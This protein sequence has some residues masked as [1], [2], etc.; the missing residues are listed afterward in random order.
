MLLRVRWDI[1]IRVPREGDS[2]TLDRIQVLFRLFPIIMYD[3]KNNIWRG[4]TKQYC[5]EVIKQN[6]GF[7]LSPDSPVFAYWIDPLPMQ[8][9]PDVGGS[10]KTPPP[11]TAMPHPRPPL[12]DLLV[13]AYMLLTSS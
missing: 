13:V 12:H 3:M 9:H 10:T 1:Y 4:A 2:Y 5:G 7:I 11:S 8:D 6:V